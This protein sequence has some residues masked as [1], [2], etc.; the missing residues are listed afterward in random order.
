MG[1]LFATPPLTIPEE[2]NEL[3]LPE[4][5]NSETP[6]FN[7]QSFSQA[8]TKAIC[9]ET[10]AARTLLQHYFHSVCDIHYFQKFDSPP[11]NYWSVFLPLKNRQIPQVYLGVTQVKGDPIRAAKGQA[12]AEN[13]GAGFKVDAGTKAQWIVNG[14]IRLGLI[15][16]VH[17]AG[18]GEGVEEG[19]APQQ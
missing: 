7:D 14:A 15:S 4:F 19:V 9:C 2:V 8:L 12:K 17:P 5:A 6:I 16:T 13:T 10:E 18:I 3:V 1:A 11:C